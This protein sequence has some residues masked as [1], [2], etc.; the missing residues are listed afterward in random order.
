MVYVTRKVH[1]NAAHRL[2]NPK[3]SDEW[4]AETYGDCNHINWHGHNYVMEVTVAGMP[5]PDTGYVI[6]LGD[7]KRILNDKIINKCDHRNLNIDVDFLKDTIPSTENLVIKFFEQIK[8]DVERASSTG[9]RL[10]SVKLFETER[11]FAEY[12][13]YMSLNY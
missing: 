5:D 1:F 12:C 7:L 9:S 11:N 10:F 8:D 6:D 13:P 2:H 4:N 3:K